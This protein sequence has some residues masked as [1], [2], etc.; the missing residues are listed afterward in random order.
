MNLKMEIPPYLK[1]L[2]P[3]LRRLQRYLPLAVFLAFVLI[4]GGLVMQ[5]GNLSRQE[6]SEDA[7]T[8]KLSSIKTPRI[9]NATL[10]KIQQLQDQNV[11]VK[12]LF[13]QARNNPFSE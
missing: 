2:G 1:K 7:V 11:D 8:E 6:P 9:D 4:C 5:I 13:D 12:S 3:Q 10:N